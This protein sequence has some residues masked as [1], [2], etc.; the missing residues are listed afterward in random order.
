[1]SALKGI[2]VLEVA[3]WTFVPAAG[4][5]LADWGADVIKVEH[6]ETGDPQRALMTSGLLGPDGGNMI[7]F[8]IEQPNRS[9]RSIG[10][11]ISKPDGHALLLRMVK[12]ADVFLTNYLPSVRK[13]LG[14][15]LEEIRAA[16]PKIIYVR[17]HGQGANGPDAD[18]GAYDAAAFWSRGGIADSLSP[19]DRAY[20]ISQGPGFGDLVGAQ[21]IAGGIAAALFKRERTG[22]GSVVDVSLLHTAMWLLSFGIVAADTMGIELKTGGGKRSETP[23]PLVGF[24]KTA[25]DRYLTLVMLQSDRYWEELCNTIGLSEIINDERFVDAGARQKNAGACVAALDAAF[26]RK[27][28]EEWKVILAGIQG[29]WAP[30]QSQ[31]ELLQ[32]PQA[33]ENQYVM[34]VKTQDGERSFKLVTSPVRFDDTA[35]TLTAAPEL[36]QHTEEFLMEIGLEWEEIE[37]YKASGAIT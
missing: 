22:E 36:G 33:I 12:D 9:K 32:D 11:D 14:I 37:A 21:T 7:N 26:A 8:M 4:A 13:K 23:N 25:D 19:T 15:N 31:M 35:P 17:G 18:R 30:V 34:D 24:Y 2:R 5:I 29:V 6:P 27:T 16:N 3:S 1:M 20:P 28:L 10:I